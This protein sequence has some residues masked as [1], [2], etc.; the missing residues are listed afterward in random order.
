MPV[1]PTSYA[2]AL[3]EDGIA[4]RSHPALAPR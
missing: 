1:K 2:Q 3:F 4:Y